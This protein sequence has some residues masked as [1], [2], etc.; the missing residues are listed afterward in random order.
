MVRV[1]PAG[2]APAVS[3]GKETIFC[4]RR[5]GVAPQANG[6][7]N[8]A[9]VAEMTSGVKSRGRTPSIRDSDGFCSLLPGTPPARGKHG[10]HARNGRSSRRGIRPSG[11][12]GESYARTADRAERLARDQLEALVV[13]DDQVVGSGADGLSERV[14][15]Q[16]RFSPVA[17]GDKDVATPESPSVL[18][19]RQIGA[20]AIA[21]PRARHRTDHRGARLRPGRAIGG[22]ADERLRF[23][24]T[25]ARHL[26][27][28]RGERLDPGG[29]GAGRPRKPGPPGDTGPPWPAGAGR[30]RRA[31]G[32]GGP[33]SAVRP[34]AMMRRAARARSGGPGPSPRCRR[35][36]GRGMPAAPRPAG[37]SGR[38]ASRRPRPRP[39]AGGGPAGS[40]A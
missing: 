35:R 17:Q 6:K 31:P 12:P 39:A 2:P 18:E 28:G 33:V 10:E 24:R 27:P 25:S 38:R 16:I 37:T 29:R 34:R 5:S 1:G 30:S 26:E 36:S 8:A 14:I 20:G 11:R 32:R 3:T 9:S 7:P 21:R 40:S 15:G 4:L 19:C 13:Q 23:V 22:D